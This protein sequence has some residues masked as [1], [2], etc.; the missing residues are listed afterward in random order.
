[1]RM[2]HAAKYEP[3]LTV[4]PTDCHADP[5]GRRAEFEREA[6]PV[7]REGDRVYAIQLVAL[8]VQFANSRDGG[9]ENSARLGVRALN[10]TQRMPRLQNLRV[11]SYSVSNVWRG[12][13]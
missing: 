2:R 3:A 7:E 11:Y 6:A 10:L 8:L 13:T 12:F 9:W 4:R 1:M 5:T